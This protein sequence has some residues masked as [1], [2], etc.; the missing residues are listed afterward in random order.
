MQLS[1]RFSHLFPEQTIR[2]HHPMV[3]QS[4]AQVCPVVQVVP[5]APAVVGSVFL[6]ACA[7]DMS[8]R[9]TSESQAI[10]ATR[11]TF[12]VVPPEPSPAPRS[13]PPPRIR[14]W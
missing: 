5:L 7:K 8:D 1:R 6:L 14:Q 12:M 13:Y 9:R 11:I 4:A 10:A 3:S 2:E